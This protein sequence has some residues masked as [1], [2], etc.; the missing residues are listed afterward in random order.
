[1]EFKLNIGSPKD[2]KCH[3]KEI[4]EADCKLLIGKKIGEIIKG[5]AI[6]F[7]GY[8]FEITGGSDYCGFPM[9]RDV[10]GAQRKRILIASGVGIKKRK[11]KGIRLRKTV[12][13]SRIYE[14]TAQ[15]N[16]KVTKYGSQPLDKP[17]ESKDEASEEKKE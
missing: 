9:R 12:A 4:K 2:K 15:I 8:E 13:G 3:K 11:R 1:M 6:D 7:P 16:L 10:E 5:E 14:K 17:E